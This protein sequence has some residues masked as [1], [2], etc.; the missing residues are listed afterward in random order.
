MIKLKDCRPI[1]IAIR[2]GV[3]SASPCVSMWASMTKITPDSSTWSD[4]QQPDE[5]QRPQPGVDPPDVPEDVVMIGPRRGDREEADQEGGIMAG[6][7]PD[8]SPEQV[9]RASLGQR[10]LDGEQR[11]RDGD[12]RIGEQVQPIRRTRLGLGFDLVI[13]HPPIISCP[14]HP[15]ARSTTAASPARLPS[16]PYAMA[17][18]RCPYAM[19]VPRCPYAMAVPRRPYAMAVPRRPYA[20]KLDL[21][22][23]G[24]RSR[25][26]CLS[27]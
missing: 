11:D 5:V 15:S 26:A 6:F 17:V 22:N 24:G 7:V 18:P 23:A 27:A 20:M 8:R 25:L 12:D 9:Y 13:G 2:C 10:K 16:H 1:S 21:R 4:H 19:A 14:G 3:P